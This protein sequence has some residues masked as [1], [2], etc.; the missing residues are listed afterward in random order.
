MRTT[1][2]RVPAAVDDGSVAAEA[3]AGGGPLGVRLR[4]TMPVSA[5]A[6]EEAKTNARKKR[7]TRTLA[8][9]IRVPLSQA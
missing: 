9:T 4:V 7:R 8:P 2:P 1:S 6:A 3:M 5:W